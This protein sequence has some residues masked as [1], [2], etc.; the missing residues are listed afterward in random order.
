MMS[1]KYLP[2]L[3]LFLVLGG[4]VYAKSGVPRGAYI[5]RPVVSGADL[6]RLVRENPT[7]KQRYIKAW[8]LSEQATLQQFVGIRLG[9]MP[10]TTPMLV[11]YFRPETGKWGYKLRTVKAGSNVFL[12]QDGTPFLMKICGNPIQKPAPKQ[13]AQLSPENVPVFNP[14]EPETDLRTDVA[15]DSTPEPFSRAERVDALATAEPVAAS[16]SDATQAESAPFVGSGGTGTGTQPSYRISASSGSGFSSAISGG[17]AGFSPVSSGGTSNGQSP[18]EQRNYSN[19]T[20]TETVPYSGSP[21]TSPT[22][23]DHLSAPEPTGFALLLV[24]GLG[25]FRTRKIT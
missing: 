8:G 12:K 21:L 23:S 3:L 5:T 11:Y 24:F 6:G 9:K 25:F 13:A 20:R 19:G 16:S 10:K 4:S 15:P 18:A 22:P 7:V 17:S 2:L 1:Q 14:T